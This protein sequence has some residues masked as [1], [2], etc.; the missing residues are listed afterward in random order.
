MSDENTETALSPDQIELNENQV[1]PLDENRYV[2]DP[3]GTDNSHSVTGT[4]DSSV[5]DRTNGDTT[6]EFAALDGAYA[7]EIRAQ[8]GTERD[9]FRVETNDV[10]EAFESLLRW[11]AGHVADD[12]PPEDVLAVLLANSTLEVD[13]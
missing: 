11:Y 3:D 12:T 6:E 2:V 8:S 10:S 9:A 13:I 5:A 1:R 7:L 4:G